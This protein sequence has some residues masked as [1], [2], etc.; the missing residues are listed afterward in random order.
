MSLVGRFV[1]VH[2]FSAASELKSLPLFGP[3]VFGRL[4]FPAAHGWESFPK[5]PPAS[6]R[7]LMAKTVVL[8]ALSTSRSIAVSSLF[9]FL[10][11]R[12]YGARTR[13]PDTDKT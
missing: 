4:G 13:L 9:M 3:S 8:I 11:M 7:F 12:F 2:V 6:I 5:L 10:G 1:T